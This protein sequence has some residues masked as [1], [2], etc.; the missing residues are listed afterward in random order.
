MTNVDIDISPPF[1]VREDAEPKLDSAPQFTLRRPVASSNVGRTPLRAF[2]R[3]QIETTPSAISANYVR[4]RRANL[5][6]ASLA[7]LYRL[8][9]R[10]PGWRGPGSRSLHSASLMGFLDFW[11]QVCSQAIEPDF[12]L[13]P[14]GN[15][16]AEWHKNVR[17]HLDIEFVDGSSAYFGHFNGK[18]VLEGIES[19]RDIVAILNSLTSSA[20][21]WKVD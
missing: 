8:A 7:T 17:R 13:A 19:V 9:A 1:T 4:L 12:V 21:R 20:L 11:T 5:S 2:D 6:D 10:R 18:K 15:L 14:N 16:I 3:D